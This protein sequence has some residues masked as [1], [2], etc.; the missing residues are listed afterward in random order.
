MKLEYRVSS[1]IKSKSE[2]TG[3][4]NFSFLVINYFLLL[5]PLK[6]YIMIITVNP[7]CEQNRIYEKICSRIN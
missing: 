4:I 2:L 6:I 1:E 3:I 7:S 5:F